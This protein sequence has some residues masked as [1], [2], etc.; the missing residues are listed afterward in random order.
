MGFPKPD[1]DVEEIFNQLKPGTA[2][3][4]LCE[5]CGLQGIA[6]YRDKP[7]TIMGMYPPRTR[8]GKLKS[9]DLQVKIYTLNG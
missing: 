5:H 4:C 9:D 3:S 2:M 1:I 8:D 6:K 7:N